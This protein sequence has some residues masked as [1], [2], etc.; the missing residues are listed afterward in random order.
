[1]NRR[2]GYKIKA[3]QNNMPGQLPLWPTPLGPP[4]VC[5]TEMSVLWR[6]NKGSKERQAHTL[7][8]HS[9]KGVHLIEVSVKRE[10]TVLLL[11]SILET[12][13]HSVDK[14][15]GKDGRLCN[16][17]I[18]F[19]ICRGHD[20]KQ[21][22]ATLTSRMKGTFSLWGKKLCAGKSSHSYPVRIGFTLPA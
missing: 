8:V 16:Q 13:M 4:S 3:E 17:I 21:Y 11:T 18:F 22:P 15:G 5:L 2:F 14:G 1:M 10:L 20:R 7:G 19:G 12:Y 6:V 9:K